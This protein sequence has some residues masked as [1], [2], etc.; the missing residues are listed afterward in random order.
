MLNIIAEL[1]PP[2]RAKIIA[3]LIAYGFRCMKYV[4]AYDLVVPSDSDVK[5]DHGRLLIEV[6]STDN[7]RRMGLYGMGC[8]ETH[9]TIE[10]LN[11]TEV[12]ALICIHNI[13]HLQFLFFAIRMIITLCVDCLH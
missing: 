3:L 13:W 11:S 2:P 9:P 8:H 12:G 7:I 10:Q 4:E 5:F 1:K 6:D